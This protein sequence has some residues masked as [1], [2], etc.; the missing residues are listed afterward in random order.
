ML[1][2]VNDNGFYINFE[3]YFEILIVH[4]HH[5]AITK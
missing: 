3:M 2:W 5:L 4:H 1:H